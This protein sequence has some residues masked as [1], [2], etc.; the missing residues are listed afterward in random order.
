[1][2]EASIVLCSVSLSLVWVS[3]QSAC[4]L[5]T[6]YNCTRYFSYSGKGK[7]LYKTEGKNPDMDTN[8]STELNASFPLI[9]HERHRK[10]KRNIYGDT[11]TQTARRSQKLFN[12]N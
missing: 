12:K 11:D 2:I 1:V 8:F 3:V 5:N 4:A 6:R 10:W 7:A 9:P